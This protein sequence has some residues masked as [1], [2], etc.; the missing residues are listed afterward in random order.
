[1]RVASMNHWMMEERKLTKTKKRDL[2]DEFV[3]GGSEE[4]KAVKAQAKEEEK[5]R[6]EKNK[7]SESPLYRSRK[8]QLPL[9]CWI[10][11][12]QNQLRQPIHLREACDT[13]SWSSNQHRNNREAMQTP[14]TE[15]MLPPAAVTCSSPGGTRDALA[16][17]KWKL[18]SVV[19]PNVIYVVGDNAYTN[20]NTFLTPF[21]DQN[22]NYRVEEDED[23]ADGLAALKGV[24]T[25]DTSVARPRKITLGIGGCTTP[26]IWQAEPIITRHRSG[27]INISL[28]FLNVIQCFAH[29]RIVFHIDVA[30]LIK[31][32]SC[33][34]N[35]EGNVEVALT[36]SR[37]PVS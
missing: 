11:W 8:R 19:Y 23:L 29:N 5:A 15:V 1:M 33:A 10:I 36:K 18:S 13:A 30:I 31:S 21:Q 22:I 17:V 34:P 27:F 32:A 7:K 35:K 25:P 4:K 37:Q 3:S 6:T 20:T 24:Q 14:G 2:K 26:P 16:Y 28:E 12:I 9:V